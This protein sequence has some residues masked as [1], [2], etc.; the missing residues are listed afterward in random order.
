METDESYRDPVD[1]AELQG[2]Q[3]PWLAGV[4]AVGRTELAVIVQTRV[5]NAT[6]LDRTPLRTLAAWSVSGAVLLFA[7]L[8]AALSTTRLR[9]LRTVSKSSA[10]TALSPDQGGTDAGEPKT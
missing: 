5:E 4:A 10:L 1:T 7:S 8:F 3:G 9:R 2:A 6:A